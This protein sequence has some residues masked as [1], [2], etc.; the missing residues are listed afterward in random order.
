MSENF[1]EN[2][3]KDYK[4]TQTPSRKVKRKKRKGK[5]KKDNIPER[6]KLL[7][8]G[9]SNPQYHEKRKIRKNGREKRKKGNIK[10]KD[11]RVV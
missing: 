10:R 3:E 9:L 11:S 6:E 8:R 2:Q 4:E 5:R 7:G 1:F